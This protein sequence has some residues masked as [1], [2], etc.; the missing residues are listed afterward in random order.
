MGA[1]DGKVA[2]ITGGAA[3]IGRAVVEAYVAAGARVGVLDR[4]SERLTELVKELGPNVVGT[5]GSVEH[6]A[7]NQRAVAQVVDAFGGLDVFVGNAGV[8]AGNLKLA[9]VPL[10]RLESAI[11]EIYDI[12]VKGYLLGA[13]AALGPLLRAPGG[14]MIFSC[15][16]AS[17]RAVDDG[18]LYVSTKHANLGIVR[19]L[20]WEFAPRIRVNGVAIGVARTRM[21]GLRCLDQE[22]IDAVLPGAEQV[23]PLGA[24]PEPHDHAGAFVYLAS[25]AAGLTTGECLW[26]DSGFGVRGIGSPAGGRDLSAEALEAVATS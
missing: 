4:D 14:C 24:I 13:R 5:V 25:S 7:D 10:D 22:P 2:L 20:A 9:E 11:D 16:L 26:T 6:L 15:S 21:E 12:N 8:G 17:Y 19:Q 18:V 23:I 3:G 1:L